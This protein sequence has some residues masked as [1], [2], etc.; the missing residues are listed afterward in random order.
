MKTK[1]IVIVALTISLLIPVHSAFAYGGGNGGGGDDASTS[2]LRD[3][4]EPPGGFEPTD[5][6]DET[7]KSG[8]YG[9]TKLTPEEENN[10]VKKIGR[11]LTPE[12]RTTLEEMKSLYERAQKAF[13]KG[14]TEDGKALRKQAISRLKK[15]PD[16]WDAITAPPLEVVGRQ[17][18]SEPIIV[19]GDYISPPASDSG[20]RKV[21]GY[22]E[23][24]KGQKIVGG[25]NGA[26]IIWPNGAKINIEANT[27]IQ[28][29]DDGFRVHEGTTWIKLR[30]NE[31]TKKFQALT[32]NVGAP[33]G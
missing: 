5:K 26:T 29:F 8:E 14:D 7:I 2:G 30:Y 17:L 22:K 32:H 3:S 33:R 9:R 27:K 10:V 19:T 20:N 6:E 16:L 13:E 11:Q 28:V 12:E 4:K 25:K 15:S 31:K 24:H 23:L 21:F 1:F 18:S